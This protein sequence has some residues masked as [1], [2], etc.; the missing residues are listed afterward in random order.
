M[1]LTN[2]MRLAY[3][4]RIALFSSGGTDM[5]KTKSVRRDLRIARS[6]WGGLPEPLVHSL[7]D[8][9]KTHNFSVTLGDLLLLNGRWYVTHSGLLRLAIRK[10]CHSIR[11]QPVREFCDA[12][13]SRFVFK[14]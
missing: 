14:A 7:V 3:A 2:A 13:R 4:K 10:R 9:L 11:V 5:K 8:S 12:A 6:I 1:P